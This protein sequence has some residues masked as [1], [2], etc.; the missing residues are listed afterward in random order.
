VIVKMIALPAVTLSCYRLWLGELALAAI[1]GFSGRRPRG[2]VI[3][4]GA[5]GGLCFAVDNALFLAALKSAPVAAVVAIGS[6]QPI[7]VL[8][9]NRYLGA[10]PSGG[11]VAC[12]VVAV[13]GVCCW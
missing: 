13:S 9:V 10:R 11:Q 12:A 6:L 5:L 3:S 2:R 4:F 1:V 7:I 8:V